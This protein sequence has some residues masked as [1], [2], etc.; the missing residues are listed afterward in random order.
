MR[1]SHLCSL[2]TPIDLKRS[3]SLARWEQLCLLYQWNILTNSSP[4]TVLDSS[5]PPAI[6]KLFISCTNPSSNLDPHLIQGEVQEIPLKLAS[7]SRVST[8]LN[9]GPAFMSHMV[10]IYTI[11]I[12]LEERIRG[13]CWQQE[14]LSSRV[15]RRS[16][17]TTFRKLS[18]SLRNLHNVIL[19]PVQGGQ[20]WNDGLEAS[21]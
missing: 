12:A 16:W 9:T 6:V 15:S 20:D 5:L 1:S 11:Q 4:H 17:F 3:L 7:F 8:Q 14:L 21:R 19:R 13:T 18:V 10:D 2:A